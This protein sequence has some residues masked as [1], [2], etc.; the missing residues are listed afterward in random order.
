M[1]SPFD[2]TGF[3]GQPERFGQSPGFCKLSRFRR[4]GLGLFGIPF[5]LCQPDRKSTR[6]NSSH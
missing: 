2:D 4:L 3:L 1:V 6:L 5:D